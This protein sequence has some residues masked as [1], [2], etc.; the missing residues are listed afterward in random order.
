MTLC[1][2]CFG[3][4][5]RSRNRD[6]LHSKTAHAVRAVMQSSHAQ[7]FS[8]K[9]DIVGDAVAFAP[10][11]HFQF[12][13]RDLRCAS[14]VASI[15]C[16]AGRDSR[17]IQKEPG[18]NQKK[19]ATSVENCSILVSQLL[20]SL[21]TERVSERRKRQTDR[22]DE[23]DIVERASVLLRSLSVEKFDRFVCQNTK[24]LML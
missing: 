10:L 11:V 12:E 1:R 14:V 22:K 24:T 9:D 16:V 19:T 4:A 23:A 2:A 17:N 8:I 15:I 6:H 18:E 20:F 13:T 7:V 5:R 3:T 21:R